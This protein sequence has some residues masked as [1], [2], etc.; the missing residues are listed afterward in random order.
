MDTDLFLNCEE[1][2]NLWIYK[3]TT[4]KTAPSFQEPDGVDFI[5]TD[6]DFS[7]SLLE[8]EHTKPEIIYVNFLIFQVS[9]SSNNFIVIKI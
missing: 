6:T 8:T 1:C 5:R 4:C 9:L 7:S 3:A 2:K